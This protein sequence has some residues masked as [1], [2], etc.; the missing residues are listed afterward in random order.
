MMYDTYE[1]LHLVGKKLPFKGLSR[2][3][4]VV[5][6]IPL[7]KH[8]ESEANVGKR[9]AAIEAWDSRRG[10]TWDVLVYTEETTLPDGLS[11][12]SRQS[13]FATIEKTRSIHI[14]VVHLTH[15]PKLNSP[16]PPGASKNDVE[17]KIEDWDEDATALFEWIGMAGFGSQRL[18]VN[19]SVDPYIAVYEPPPNTFIGGI[20]H[21]SWRGFF[22]PQF[23]QKL[24]DAIIMLCSNPSPH[25]IPFMSLTAHCF[26]I[27]PVTFLP[28]SLGS[29][30]GSTKQPAPRVPRADGEDTWHLAHVHG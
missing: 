3:I 15:R 2:T 1:G 14:P 5:I 18:Q 29:T 11:G 21:L 8:V 4:R 27:S 22:P 9:N 25:S 10:R 13:T 20:T 6:T 12:L 26:L 19:D 16:R 24:L 23:V 28:S 30:A 17:D 7:Q